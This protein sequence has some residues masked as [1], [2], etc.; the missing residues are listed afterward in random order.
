MQDDTDGWIARPG[1]Q[2]AVHGVGLLLTGPSGSGKSSLALAL[3]E[4]GHRL[5]SDDAPLLRRMP[6]GRIEGRAS[7]LLYGL[8]HVRGLGVLDLRHRFGATALLPRHRLDLVIRL[9]PDPEPPLMDLNLPGVSLPELTLPPGPSLALWV[10]CAAHRWLLE[11]AGHD[12]GRELARQQA[13]QIAE[14]SPCA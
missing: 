7:D 11:R 5:I 9:A 12:A 1:V 14:Q 3:V 13:K 4:R 8:L 10:E 6:D 2:L